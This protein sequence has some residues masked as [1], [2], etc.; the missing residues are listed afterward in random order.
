MGV[1]EPSDGA[2]PP[3]EGLVRA[4]QRPATPFPQKVLAYQ[5]TFM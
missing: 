4:C 2:G 1:Y 3:A 5:H